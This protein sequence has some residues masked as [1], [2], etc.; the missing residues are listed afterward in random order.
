[1]MSISTTLFGDIS[2]TGLFFYWP[3]AEPL[4]YARGTLGLRGTPVENHCTNLFVGVLLILGQVCAY[5][6]RFQHS[7]QCIVQV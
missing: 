3:A 1:M 2:H 5:T 4:A 7:L 6:Y